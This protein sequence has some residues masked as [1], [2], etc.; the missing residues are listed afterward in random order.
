MRRLPEENLK[1]LYKWILL[2]KSDS[3][4]LPI[5]STVPKSMLSACLA[6][7]MN[8]LQDMLYRLMNQ[9]RLFHWFRSFDKQLM[10]SGLDP[11]CRFPHHMVSVSPLLRQDNWNQKNC[12]YSLNPLCSNRNKSGLLSRLLKFL[13]SLYSKQCGPRSDCSYRSNLIWVHPVCFY[14]WIRQ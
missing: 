8:T 4:Y 11:D 12:S 3:S 10:N 2:G 13:K 14:T 6:V 7:S 9:P 5:P 1:Y